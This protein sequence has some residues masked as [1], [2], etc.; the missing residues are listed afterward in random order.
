M[1]NIIRLEL[2][3]IAK[4]FNLFFID[5]ASMDIL[6]DSINF[7]SECVNA[8]NF[9]S[10]GKFIIHPNQLQCLKN[11]K[12]FTDKEVSWAKQI[13]SKIDTE[14]SNIG[15]VKYNDEVIEKPHLN[16]LLNIKKYIDEKKL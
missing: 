16:K 9:G 3:S 14:N 15:A 2:V 5:T 4:A 10:Y 11:A 12:Y 8:F 6:H 7:K 13:L 1:L